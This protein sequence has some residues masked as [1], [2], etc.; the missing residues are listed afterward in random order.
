M[1]KLLQALILTLAIV[2][3]GERSARSESF[4]SFDCPKNQVIAHGLNKKWKT[5]HGG[6][7][8]FYAEFPDVPANTPVAV[9]FSWHGAGE[10]ANRWRQAFPLAEYST[11]SFPFIVITPKDT[12]LKPLG[13]RK[14]MSWDLFKSVRGDDNLEVALFENVLGCLSKNH[15]IAVDRIYAAGFSGGGMVANMLHSRYPKIVSAVYAGSGSWINDPRQRDAIRIPFG[16]S[17]DMRWTPLDA[18]DRGAVLMTYGGK[19]DA[20]T[21]LGMEIVNFRNAG[22]SASE[23]L[24]QHGRTAIVCEHDGGHQFHPL[25][26]AKEVVSFFKAHSAKNPSPYRSRNDLP[27]MMANVCTVL[28]PA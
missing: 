1:Q 2:V 9:I 26:Q 6:E 3:L 28:T 14:G 11:A 5:Q 13:S 23:F 24:P 22:I 21:F 10:D 18:N 8:Q 27:R 7:R 12:G 20:T 15:N 16:I 4:P 25:I 19:L 17:I